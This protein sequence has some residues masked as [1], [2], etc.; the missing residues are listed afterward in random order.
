MRGS[1][2]L[3]ELI[4]QDFGIDLPISGG[5]GNSINDPIIITTTNRPRIWITTPFQT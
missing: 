5:F 4:E 3:K 2:M 1:S